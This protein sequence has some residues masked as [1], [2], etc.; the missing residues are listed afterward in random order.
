MKPID[1][2][3]CVPFNL[4]FMPRCKNCKK[5]FEAYSIEPAKLPVVNR[6]ALDVVKLTCPVC[7]AMQHL[8]PVSLSQME[9][10]IQIQHAERIL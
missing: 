8:L 6:P 10:N 4:F 3:L 1:F 9:S 5:P 7:G 2:Y